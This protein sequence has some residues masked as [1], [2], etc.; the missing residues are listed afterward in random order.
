MRVYEDPADGLQDAMRLAEGMTYKWAAAGGSY[1]GGKAV[2][3]LSRELSH[4]ERVALLMKYGRLLESM[5]GMFSTGPDLGTTPADMAELAK[6]SP[7]VHG[8]DFKTGEAEDTSPY[9]AAGVFHGIRAAVEHVDGSDSLV[10]KTVVVQGVGNV[11]A[12]LARLVTNAGGNVVV[13][14]VDEDRARALASEIDARVVHEEDVYGVECDVHAPCAIGATLNNNSIPRLRCRMVVGGANNQLAEPEDALLLQDFGI[15]YAPDYVVNAGGAIGLGVLEHESEEKRMAGVARI[16]E[17][18]REIL[19]DASERD[20]TPVEAAQSLV[21]SR[22]EARR[23]EGLIPER[24][25]RRRK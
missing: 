18:L 7:H 24:L 17:T 10:G 19:R 8:V 3:A 23:R 16:G 6:S 1:G 4:P 11:G 2:L 20:V 5:K 25:V 13:Q 12:T 21:L 22:V 9:T 14:D 15:V